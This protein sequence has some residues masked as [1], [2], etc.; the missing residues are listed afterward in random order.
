MVVL[1]PPGTGKSFMVDTVV[2]MIDGFG[3]G[4]YFRSQVGRRSDPADLLGVHTLA[5]LN[6][7]RFERN[8]TNMLPEASVAVI[9]EFW[10][11]PD[12]ATDDLRSIL[13]EGV[14]YNGRP[15]Q[16]PLCTLVVDSNEMPEAGH[17]LA[18]RFTFW[19]MVK[20]IMGLGNVKTML[21]GATQRLHAVGTTNRPVV[22]KVIGWK[23][24]LKAQGAVAAVAIPDSI[25]TALAELRA[26]L[27]GAGIYPSDRRLV[28]CLGVM[29]AQA[30][31]AGRSE[32][33][34]EDMAL[35]AHVLWTK[36]ADL[37]KVQRLV[38]T[39][40]S[41]FD[42]RAMDLSSRVEA[43]ATRYTDV[44]AIADVVTRKQRLLALHVEISGDK[45]S[46]RKGL[47]HDLTALREEA[48]A[49]GKP[50]ALY[51]ALAAQAKSLGRSLL[52][53]LEALEP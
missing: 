53:S 23:D 36:P 34:T 39:I 32:V 19:L 31:R 43:M 22:E 10:R 2:A 38:Y 49:A 29:Q 21:A 28:S 4:D 18:D 30:Y 13:N 35:L 20:P 7:G 11:A 14:F 6:E 41:P 12:S 8:T 47:G 44:L 3:P 51:P 27:A 15:Q 5:A 26:Q 45:H 9:G 40:S 52:T 37:P 1:G 50:L 46:G 33:S 17:A 42:L 24:I 25:H 48:T 16:V